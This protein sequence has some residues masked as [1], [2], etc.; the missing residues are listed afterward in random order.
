MLTIRN[1]LLAVAFACACAA[2]WIRGGD[3]DGTLTTA[4]FA[5]S[6]IIGVGAYLVS[7]GEDR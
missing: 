5:A 1:A 3:G 7:G 6:L 2:G 4:L